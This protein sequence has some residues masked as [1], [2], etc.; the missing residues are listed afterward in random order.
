LG[1]ALGKTQLGKTSSRRFLLIE[2]REV[3]YQ[4]LQQVIISDKFLKNVPTSLLDFR[5]KN[6]TKQISFFAMY[7]PLIANKISIP[8]HISSTIL[9]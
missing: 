6:Y 5:A 1:N 9:H 7:S 2:L 4:S 3:S 8:V